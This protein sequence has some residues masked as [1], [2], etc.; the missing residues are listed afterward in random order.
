MDAAADIL[1]GGGFSAAQA[2]TAADL[3]GFPRCVIPNPAGA[4]PAPGPPV[5]PTIFIQQLRAQTPRNKMSAGA[6]RPYAFPSP[7]RIYQ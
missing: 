3:A 6:N 1:A 4:T 2:F 5:S 7:A